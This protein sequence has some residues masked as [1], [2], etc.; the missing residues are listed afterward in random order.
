MHVLVCLIKMISRT[1]HFVSTGYEFTKAKINF[2]GHV[3]LSLLCILRYTWFSANFTKQSLNVG[4]CSEVIPLKISSKNINIYYAILAFE[5]CQGR[6][7]NIRWSI[8]LS[9][10]Y[11]W[12]QYRPLSQSPTKR[13]KVVYCTLPYKLSNKTSHEQVYYKN[14][15]FKAD[16][17]YKR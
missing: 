11:I 9:S 2:E 17:Y 16:L 6:K 8:L 15:F 1:C 13:A 12:M 10:F 4:K 14:F 7:S 5:K 3:L